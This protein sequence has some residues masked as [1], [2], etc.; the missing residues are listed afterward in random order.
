MGEEWNDQNPPIFSLL[1]CLH[2]LSL[3]KFME[4]YIG[5][6][7]AVFKVVDLQDVIFCRG[8]F[9]I[10]YY[11]TL[12]GRVALLPQS[13]LAISFVNNQNTGAGLF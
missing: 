13:Q 1:I 4:K 12:S 11:F 8:I 9:C 7:L 6:Y 3:S 2:T 10:G 5:K